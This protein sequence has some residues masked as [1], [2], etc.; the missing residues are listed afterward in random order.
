VRL[1]WW[2]STSPASWEWT[3]YIVEDGLTQASGI[4]LVDQEGMPIITYCD[5]TSTDIKF[6]RLVES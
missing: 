2:W 6:A 5:V 3:T 1:R 4:S